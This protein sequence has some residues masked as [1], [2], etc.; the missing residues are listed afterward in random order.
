MQHKLPEMAYILDG[1]CQDEIDKL[2][3]AKENIDIIVRCDT[4]RYPIIFHL[5][6]DGEKV[7]NTY[8]DFPCSGKTPNGILTV[9]ANPPEVNTQELRMPRPNLAPIWPDNT[10][11]VF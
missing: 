10:R 3:K 7:G 8:K 9:V 6:F 1:L 2:I 5:S 4:C 11:R